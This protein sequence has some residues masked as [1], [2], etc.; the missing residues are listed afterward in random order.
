M[1]S[2]SLMRSMAADFPTLATVR[3]ALS[4]SECMGLHPASLMPNVSP[5]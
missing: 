2:S 5:P 4:I 3:I 1:P